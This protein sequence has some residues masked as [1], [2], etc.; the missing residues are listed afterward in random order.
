MLRCTPQAVE[1][2]VRSAIEEAARGGGFIVG[3]GCTLA[4]NTPL[5]NYNAVARAVEKYG[6]YRR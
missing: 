4:Q 3:P 6:W 5:V 2:E 1:E